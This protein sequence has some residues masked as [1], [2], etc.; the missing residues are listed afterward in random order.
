MHGPVA[1]FPWGEVI[2]EFLDPLGLTAADFASRMRGGWLFGY[3][4]ALQRQGVASVIVCGSESV[5][6]A[7]RLIHAETAAPIWL[8]PARRSGGRFTRSRPS[9]RSLAQ[10][11]RTP[12]RG[13]AAVLRRERCR[14][15]IVQ[16]YEHAR[17]DALAGLGNVLGLKVYASFQGGEVILSDAEGAVRPRSLRL[18]DALIVSSRRERE[19]L[20]RM[21]GVPA[22]RMLDIANPVDVDT[23][24]AG[25]RGGARATLGVPDN[26]FLVVNHGRVDIHRKGLDVV[27]DAWRAFAPGRPEARL[28]LIGSGQDDERF[29]PMAAA[30]PQLT[31]IRGYVTDPE[32][33]RRWLSAADAYVTLSRVEGMPVA[34]LEAMACGLPIVASDA[35]GLA[36]ILESG[37]QSGGLLVARGDAGAASAALQ[38]LHGDPGLRLRLGQAARGTVVARYGLDAVGARLNDMLSSAPGARAAPRPEPRMQT[39]LEVS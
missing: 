19:R 14:A 24:R 5:H 16:D 2:E 30:T 32:M 23:W 10:W 33:I 4:A 39:R 31:W 36:D 1:I 9:L 11:V 7:E 25:D 26:A 6:Q 21:H 15:I 3:V 12:V 20:G 37:E 35:H 18:C 29:A 28:V 8:V 38:R 27:L 13:F 34:P 22:G 17:F